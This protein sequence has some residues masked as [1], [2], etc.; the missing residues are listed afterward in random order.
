MSFS[1]HVRGEHANVRAA[2]CV[3]AGSSVLVRLKR[4]AKVGP[5][6]GPAKRIDMKS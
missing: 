1:F 4:R 3:L 2:S 6:V 5:K